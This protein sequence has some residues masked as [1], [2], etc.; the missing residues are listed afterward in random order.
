MAWLVGVALAAL[1]A[2]LSLPVVRGL[3]G[4][5]FDGL[6]GPVSGGLGRRVRSRLAGLISGN[7]TRLACAGLTRCAGGGRVGGP[8]SLIRSVQCCECDCVRITCG[9]RP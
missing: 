4:S 6:A 9:S 3:V 1:L 8:D 5:S 2:G 7:R